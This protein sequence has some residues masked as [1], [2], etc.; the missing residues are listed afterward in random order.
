VQVGTPLSSVDDIKALPLI[1]APGHASVKLG[2]V[3][4]VALQDTEV[5]SITRTN[6]K[7]S[8]GISVTAAPSGNAVGISNE[9]K[10]KIPSLVSSPGGQAVLTP[11]FDRAPF[12]DRW[13]DGLTTEGGLGL[14]MAVLVILVFL[15]SIRSTLVTAVS[16]PLSV[17]VALIALK[18]F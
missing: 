11:V 10:D 1:A 3:A 15:L 9:I 8:L 14:L 5:D 7:P 17:I 13:I 18:V 12:V 16:I 4:T 6:G 2:D